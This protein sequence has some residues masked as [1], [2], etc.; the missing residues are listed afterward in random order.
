MSG[1]LE[2]LDDQ[3]Y[4]VLKTVEK[5][6]LQTDTERYEAIRYEIDTLYSNL[7]KPKLKSKEKVKKKGSQQRN[8]MKL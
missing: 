6:R 7:Y 2:R 1:K 3:I 5:S 4:Q 8:K